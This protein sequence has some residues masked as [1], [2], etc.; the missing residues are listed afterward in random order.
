MKMINPFTLICDKD[1][2]PVDVIAGLVCTDVPH[3][4]VRE[5]DRK[6]PEDAPHS[7]WDWDGEIFKR[8]PD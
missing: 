8:T 1:G 4:I 3:A 2:D 6:R 5:W 7:S